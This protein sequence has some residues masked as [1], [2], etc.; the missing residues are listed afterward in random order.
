MGAL[1]KPFDLTYVPAQPAREESGGY[2]QC[3]YFITGYGPYREVN[4]RVTGYVLSNGM[5]IPLYTCDLVRDPIYTY[6]CEYIPYV[7][8]SPGAPARVD[9]TARVGW[10]AGATSTSSFSG[11]CELAFS[12]DPVAGAY[13]GL[14]DVNWG[15]DPSRLRF[16]FLLYQAGGRQNFSVVVDGTQRIAPRTYGSG[17]VFKIQRAAGALTFLV[18]DM[19]VYTA[20]DP[21][22]GNTLWAGTTLYAS[23]DAVPEFDD[24]CPTAPGGT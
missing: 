13:V 10:D 1:R 14:T 23:G 18:N 6:K 8:A 11:D 24:C 19:V 16:A 20:P 3:G 7:P 17:D 4:C 15:A 12:L 9:K 21:S 22:V 2:T 5:F